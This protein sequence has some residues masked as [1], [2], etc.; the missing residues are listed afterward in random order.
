MGA[1]LKG[2]SKDRVDADSL[3]LEEAFVGFARFASEFSKI[4]LF[5]TLSLSSDKSALQLITPR[6][7]KVIFSKWTL[8]ILTLLQN[9]V[10]M[11]FY[12]IYKT[13]GGVSTATLSKKLSWLEGKEVIQRSVIDTKPPTV[14]YALTVKGATLLALSE[15]LL[16]YLRYHEALEHEKT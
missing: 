4:N 9:R 12:D 5:S 1:E 7:A 2:A 3:L 11:R 13:L 6:I 10:T 16:L 8:E 14:R 15:P